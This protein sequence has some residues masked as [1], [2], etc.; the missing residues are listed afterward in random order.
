MRQLWQRGKLHELGQLRGQ[1]VAAATSPESGSGRTCK[2]LSDRLRVERRVRL[3][4]V[5]VQQWLLLRRGLQLQ[6]VQHEG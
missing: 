4:R 5:G 1:F 2:Q 6:S 3:R